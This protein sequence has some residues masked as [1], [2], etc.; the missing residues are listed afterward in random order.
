MQA[1]Q[2]FFS[3]WSGTF[4]KQGIV[5]KVA[6]GC[7]SFFMFCCLCSVPIGL[8]NPSKSTPEVTETV[9]VE[10]SPTETIIPTIAPSNT[11]APTPTEKAKALLPGL[12]PADVTLNLEQRGFTCGKVEQ[13]QLYYVRTCN[14]DT[15]T[16]SLRVEVYGRELFSVDFIDS[17]IMQYSTP[18]YELAASFL[19]FM[20]TMPYDGAVQQEARSWVESTVPTIKK[21][22]DMAEKVFAG[23]TY[24]LKGI[25]TAIT[26][27]MG[28]LP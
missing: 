20:A 15:V 13:G 28:D 25:S 21:Q 12:M 4:K 27:E 2:R 9:V 19:G 1:V 18:D 3:W 22:G 10:V 24:R 5:G 26:L 17:T 6:V 14:K 7:F 11:P 8:L 16:Y 23:V